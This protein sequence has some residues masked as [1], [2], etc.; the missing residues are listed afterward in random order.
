LSSVSSIGTYSSAV[1]GDTQGSSSVQQ[2]AQAAPSS[3][4]FGS[5]IAANAATAHAAPSSSGGSLADLF[6]QNASSASKTSQSGL[7]WL[8]FVKIPPLDSSLDDDD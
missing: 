6:T 1:F 2:A 3:V 4:D 5:L 7:D 8:G